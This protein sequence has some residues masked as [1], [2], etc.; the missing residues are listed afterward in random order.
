MPDVSDMELLRDY[1]RQWGFAGFL[2]GTP[3]ILLLPFNASPD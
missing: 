2:A 1:D 3:L